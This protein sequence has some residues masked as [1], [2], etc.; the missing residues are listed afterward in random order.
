MIPSIEKASANLIAFPGTM[1]NAKSQ[2]NQTHVASV[3]ASSAHA[4]GV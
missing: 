1:C 4:H 3:G 2:P